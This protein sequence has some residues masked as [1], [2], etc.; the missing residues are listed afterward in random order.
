[1]LKEVHKEVGYSNMAWYSSERSSLK[2]NR[3]TAGFR[4][5]FG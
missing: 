3:S 5:E 2:A 1:M 4:L